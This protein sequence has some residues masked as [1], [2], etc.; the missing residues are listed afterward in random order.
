MPMRP[1]HTIMACTDFSPGAE[2]AVKCAAW[3][4]VARNARLIV[5]SVVEMPEHSYR[6]MVEDLTT[7]R[8]ELINAQL[9]ALTEELKDGYGLDAA[10][11]CVVGPVVAELLDLVRAEGVDLLVCGHDKQSRWDDVTLGSAAAQLLYKAPCDVLVANFTHSDETLRVAVP[12]DMSEA[13]LRAA[14]SAIRTVVRTGGDTVHVVHAVELPTGWSVLGLGEEEMLERVSEH[15]RAELD[16]WLGR[17]DVAGLNVE[18]TMKAGRPV[19]VLKEVC[20]AEGINMI[21]CGAHGR[22][23]AASVVLGRQARRFV[24]HLPTSFWVVRP[25]EQ[26]LGFF[27]A[28][29]RLFST[30]TEG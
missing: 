28:V 9:G 1:I 29:K 23:A 2:H 30:G 3:L 17:L 5:V 10:M 7:A 8:V 15:H 26:V 16:D 6:F 11:H 12:T 27:E 20:A 21:F 18:V 13:A 25:A 14:Q 19:D 24:H 4:A 22:T